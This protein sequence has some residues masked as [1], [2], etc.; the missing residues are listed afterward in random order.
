MQQPLHFPEIPVTFLSLQTLFNLA[1]HFNIYIKMV[2][3]FDHTV[4]GLLELIRIHSLNVTL[5]T[6]CLPCVTLRKTAFQEDNKV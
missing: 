5:L 6:D 3:T 4:N 1:K 2:S